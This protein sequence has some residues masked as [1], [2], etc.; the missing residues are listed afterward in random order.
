MTKEDNKRDLVKKVDVFR[1]GRFFM[2]TQWFV[3][4]DGK[5][6][7][8]ECL[9]ADFSFEF[10]SAQTEAVKNKAALIL[11]HFEREHDL[12]EAS[13]NTAKQGSDNGEQ[14]EK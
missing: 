11:E 13:D 7:I 2:L 10:T 14:Y 9:N 5:R 3:I 6:F 8:V 4:Y 1:P 12:Y